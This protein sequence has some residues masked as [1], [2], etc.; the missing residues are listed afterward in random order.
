MAFDGMSKGD[1]GATLPSSSMHYIVNDGTAR[2][3]EVSDNCAAHARELQKRLQDAF[4]P[5]YAKD[6]VWPDG[7]LS[8]VLGMAIII[9]MSCLLWIAI[10]WALSAFT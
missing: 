2:I 10:A 8:P 4:T 9:C 6:E 7:Y 3:G 1:R 5:P